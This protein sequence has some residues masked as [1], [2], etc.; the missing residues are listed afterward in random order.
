VSDDEL[1]DELTNISEFLDLPSPP[2]PMA[3]GP[4]LPSSMLPHTPLST[5][6]PMDQPTNRNHNHGQLSWANILAN[7]SLSP[8]AT[9]PTS[10]IPN[11]DQLKPIMNWDMIGP[12]FHDA[13]TEKNKH[14]LNPLGIPDVVDDDSS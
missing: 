12:A 7:S 8:P 9:N 6:Q 2:V 11:P 5:D 4:Q 14:Q 10:A 3:S 1:E 13:D